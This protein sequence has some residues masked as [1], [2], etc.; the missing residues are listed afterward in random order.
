LVIL[1]E[2]LLNPAYKNIQ[3]LL[4]KFKYQLSFLFKRIELSFLNNNFEINPTLYWGANIVI[5]E[6]N[7]DQS[8]LELSKESY[9]E[10]LLYEQAENFRELV[11]ADINDLLVYGKAIICQIIIRSGLL[12]VKDKTIR[13]YI[14]Y[15]M[16]EIHSFQ[17]N[18]G[19]LDEIIRNSIN[20]FDLD[21]LLPNIL[22]LK[23]D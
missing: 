12:F 23:L 2:Y 14:N 6:H 22:R 17:D 15:I 8:D 21:K 11:N 19:K 10:D 4:V 5:D 7:S 3:S 18:S 20:K 1:S 9:A 13:D 16:T